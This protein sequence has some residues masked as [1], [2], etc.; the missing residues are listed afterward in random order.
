MFY[1][2][3]YRP[4][5]KTRQLGNSHW[6]ALRKAVAEALKKNKDA[7]W[8]A[9]RDDDGMYVGRFRR[10]FTAYPK[11]RPAEYMPDQDL[12]TKPKEP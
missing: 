10:S 7:K 2:T 8:G 11:E 3:I 12:F 6:D 5:G 1:C 4:G 9:L